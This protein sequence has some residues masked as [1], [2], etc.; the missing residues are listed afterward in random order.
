MSQ[1]NAKTYE[2]DAVNYP[3]M[4]L[5][6]G[7]QYGLIAQDV[8]QVLPGI[9]KTFINPEQEVNGNIIP[10]VSFK[11]VNYDILI[12]ILV[13]AFQ[14]QK[15]ALDSVKNV[16]SGYI[17]QP[18]SQSQNT[19]QKITLSDAQAI[20]LRQNDPNPFAENTVIRFSIPENIHNAKLIFTNASGAILKT[21]IIESRGEGSLEVYASD[22][23]S[24]IYTY[25]LVCDGKIIDSKKMMKD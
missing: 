2:F 5:P 20:V 23:S 17:G 18:R 13:A 24:G 11:A 25:T 10:P 8:E 1:L 14:E 9:V 16:L 22:L 21:A 7:L 4:S 6:S 3:S 19:S 15:N 12:P